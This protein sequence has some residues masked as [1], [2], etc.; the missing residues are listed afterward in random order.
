MIK[1]YSSLKDH[2][3]YQLRNLDYQFDVDDLIKAHNIDESKIINIQ[4]HQEGRWL[5]T[6]IFT[7][8]PN[9]QNRDIPHP[10]L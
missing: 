7:R 1:V 8:E 6:V 2:S 5:S 9:V 3:S 4:S 10:D